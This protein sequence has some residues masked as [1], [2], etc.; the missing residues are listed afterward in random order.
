MNIFKNVN[1]V[2]WVFLLTGA[3]AMWDGIIMIYDPAH[4]FAQYGLPHAKG[5]ELLSQMT[6]V[7][8]VGVAL[9][10]WS[11]MSVYPKIL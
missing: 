3:A 4:F 9:M 2:S 5:G 11:M 7:M 1:G 8:F 6:G 10:L